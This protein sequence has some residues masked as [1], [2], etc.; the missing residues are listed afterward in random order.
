[1]RK[2]YKILLIMLHGIGL[3]LIGA[4]CFSRVCFYA[5]WPP[6]D[7]VVLWALIGMV[8]LTHYSLLLMGHKFQ[9]LSSKFLRFFTVLEIMYSCV[10]VAAIILLWSIPLFNPSFGAIYPMIATPVI[11]LAFRLITQRSVFRLDNPTAS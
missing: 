8:F 5:T 10:Q 11:A 4:A 2:F 7:D 9:Y 6:E 3:V 1:M